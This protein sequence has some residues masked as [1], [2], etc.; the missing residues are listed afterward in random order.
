MATIIVN[1]FNEDNDSS[2]SLLSLREAIALAS[3]GD[4]IEFD[5][6]LSGATVQLI[7]N[8]PSIRT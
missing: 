6:S 8:S 2:N 5:P 7:A 4:T 3:S 1:T